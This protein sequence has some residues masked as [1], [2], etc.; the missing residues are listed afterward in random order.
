[1][2]PLPAR[3]ARFVG[4]W[5][6]GTSKSEEEKKTQTPLEITPGYRSLSWFEQRLLILSHP[7]P[8]SSYTDK[9]YRTRAWRCKGPL[10]GLHHTGCSFFPLDTGSLGG[11]LYCSRKKSQPV[12]NGSPDKCG[13]SVFRNPRLDSSSTPPLRQAGVD[14]SPHA[15]MAGLSLF[16]RPCSATPSISKTSYSLFYLDGSRCAARNKAADSTLFLFLRKIVTFFF[17]SCES[18][19]TSG[20]CACHFGPETARFHRKPGQATDR[21][22]VMDYGSFS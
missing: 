22:G 6:K 18:L 3:Q 20:V 4:P 11:L 21:T 1:M 13:E 8:S 14:Q 9:A 17:S 16:F 15:H 5:T 19:I 10:F 7:C 2:L 12:K